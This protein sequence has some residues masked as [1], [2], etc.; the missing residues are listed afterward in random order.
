MTS[1]KFNGR[2]LPVG[3]GRYV[4]SAVVR[5]MEAG[6]P[7]FFLLD[8]YDAAPGEI[9]VGTH[10]LLAQRVAYIEEK[11]FADL[12]IE[13]PIPSRSAFIAGLNTDGNGATAQHPGRQQQDAATVDRWFCMRM[14]ADPAIAANIL[15]AEYTPLETWVPMAY[16]EAELK[17]LLRR[18]HTLYIQIKDVVAVKKI[19]RF[20]TPRMAMR[21]RQA[22]TAGFT[23][24]E[25]KSVLLFGWKP[26][27][28]NIVN[29]LVKA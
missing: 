3:N 7:F 5:L 18:A 1:G 21:A 16:T 12:P 19:K 2:I 14:D 17:A 27:E 8:E 26:D 4:P 22:L 15:G 25:M 23:W 28:I 10:T 29:E 20:V 24:E 6:E 13:T 11:S 9:Q